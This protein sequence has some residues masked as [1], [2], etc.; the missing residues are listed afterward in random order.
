MLRRAFEF[1]KYND[2]QG[3]YLEFGVWRG[4]TLLN[5]VKYARLLKLKNGSRNM[6]FFGFDSFQGLPKI[7]K[8]GLKG[9]VF[10]PGQFAHPL[11]I[12]E[13][14][15]PEDTFLIPGWFKDTLNDT[16]KMFNRFDGS[17]ISR[18]SVIWVDCDL[19]EST[20]LVLEFIKNLLVDGTVLIFDDWFCYRG[21]PNKGEQK[22]FYNWVRKHKIKYSDF[23]QFGWA[24]KSFIIH[25]EHL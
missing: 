1:V 9:S 24:G 22:A 20:E 19:F 13:K 2:V 8:S 5:A 16:F 3:D 7:D 23:Q 18:A 4:K 14:M 17:G 6:R 10:F 12:L 21:D 25:K 11:N 15:I